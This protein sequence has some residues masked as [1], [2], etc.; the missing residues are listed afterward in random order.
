[1]VTE[2]MYFP[3]IGHCRILMGEK[4]EIVLIQYHLFAF[5][6][7]VYFSNGLV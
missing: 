4:F 1:M 3:Y 5:G 6:D 7:V 2:K